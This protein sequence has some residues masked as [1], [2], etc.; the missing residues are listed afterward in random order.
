MSKRK[1]VTV[2][3][4]AIEEQERFIEGMR[5]YTSRYEAIHGHKPRVLTQTFGCPRV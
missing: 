5:E 3:V 1:Q 4:E 2:P